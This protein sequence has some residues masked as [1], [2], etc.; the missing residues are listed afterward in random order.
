MKN[1]NINPKIV[2]AVI[3]TLLVASNIS[4]F[5]TGQKIIRIQTDTINNSFESGLRLFDLL[6]KIVSEQEQR[7]AQEE[8]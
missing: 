3:I 4:I 2:V 1:P 5:V 6:D 8:K 7:V